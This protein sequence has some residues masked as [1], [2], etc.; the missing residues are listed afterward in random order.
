MLKH[1]SI[2]LFYVLLI[3]VALPALCFI[4]K[5]SYGKIQI[6][7]EGS[8]ENEFTVE[9]IKPED[10]SLE[11]IQKTASS[12]EEEIERLEKLKEYYETNIRR[13]SRTAWRLEFKDPGYSRILDQRVAQLQKKL[14]AVNKRLNELQ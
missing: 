6:S 8:A 11:K 1:R 2:Q 12:R 5:A 3:G 13:L 9:A 7:S 10:D 14:D 4:P